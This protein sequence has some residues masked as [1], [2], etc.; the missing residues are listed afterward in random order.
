MSAKIYLVTG[1]SAG[2]G[3]ETARALG[4]RG[5]RVWIVGRNPERTAAA[6]A[7]VAAAGAAEA[8]AFR[9]D[10]S[11]LAAVR[12]LA[13]E[14]LALGEPLHVLVNNAGLWHQRRRESAEGFEDTFAVNHLAPFLL[15]HLLLPRLL[16][17]GDDVRVV[18]VSSR[19]HEQAGG[20]RGPGGRVFGRAGTP[21]GRLV[22]LAGVLKLPRPPLAAAGF[23]FDDL[24]MTGRYEGIE[25][26]ARSKLAQ[27]LFSMELARRLATTPVTS[28]AVH[29][30]SVAT[31][32]T[33]ESP[34]LAL[35][36]R[37]VTG[38]LK[39]PEE[40]AR[41]TLHV[42]TEPS[43]RGVTGEYFADARRAEPS[44]AARDRAS[45][46]RLWA[47]SLRMCGLDDEAL[48]PAV[49]DVEHEAA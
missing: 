24:A 32:V 15:T 11:S 31:E 3:L 43:L 19:L 38:I 8:R 5:A 14:V 33:R 6:R 30:G 49:R 37:L 20:F 46:R 34:V 21:T 26:Y 22:H 16:E 35:G 44:P 40:G 9:A 39:T 13:D 25:A 27:L 17:S 48:A 7:A 10:F 2:I 36:Q 12:G 45:A 47:L 1:A 18:H 29:P 42:A 23:D 4:A 28:N 41:T